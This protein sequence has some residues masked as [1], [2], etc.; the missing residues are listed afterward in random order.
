M[1][2]NSLGKLGKHVAKCKKDLVRSSRYLIFLNS[3]QGF[4]INKSFYIK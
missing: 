2:N 3:L 1:L 4:S